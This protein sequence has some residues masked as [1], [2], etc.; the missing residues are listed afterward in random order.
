MTRTFV[1]AAALAAAAAT[2]APTPKAGKLPPPTAKEV[3][4]SRNNLRQ[5]GLAIHSYH[6]TYGRLPGD[7]VGK[8]REPLLSWRVHLLPFLDEERLY[9][10]FKM[11]EA[12]DR[13]ANK[14]LVEKLPKVYAPVR[15]RA[16][17]GHT[18]YRGFAGPGALFEPGQ[19]LTIAAIPDGS[20]N[21][22]LVVE[23]GEPVVWTKPD[24]LPYDP[25]KPLPKLGGL[26]DG[27]FHLLT[28]DGAVHACRADFNPDVFRLIV[29]RADG[30][31]V[32]FD[33]VTVPKK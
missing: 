18:F 2:A 3:E 7:V 16:E 26:F 19:R 8:D 30:Q 32:D 25:K 27:M 17:A 22:A 23:A 6:D 21:T 28:A 9:K 12:W 20:S 1:L 31:V 33:A 5:I 24:D 29:T 10:Q 15:V 4:A 13:P 11:D 14:K